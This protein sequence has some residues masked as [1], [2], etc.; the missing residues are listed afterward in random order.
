MKWCAGRLHVKL[1]RAVQITIQ[2]QYLL[3]TPA[4]LPTSLPTSRD[5]AHVRSLPVGNWNHRLFVQAR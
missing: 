2:V 3:F 1:L 4:R 5:P